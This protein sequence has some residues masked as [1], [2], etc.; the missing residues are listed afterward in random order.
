MLF[1][2]FFSLC[3]YRKLIPIIQ[4]LW[5]HIFYYCV[6]FITILILSVSLIFGFKINKP[7][8]TIIEIKVGIVYIESFNIIDF[9]LESLWVYGL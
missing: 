4:I 5:C 8:S 9:L 7:I 2:L 1:Y 6:L 3:K